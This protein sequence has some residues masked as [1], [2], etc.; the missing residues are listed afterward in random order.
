MAREIAP[1]EHSFYDHM[2]PYAACG[3]QVKVVMG[4]QLVP[5]DEAAAG[6]CPKCAELV[7]AGRPFRTPPHERAPYLCE[8]YL[9]LSVDGRVT[10]EECRLRDFHQGPHRTFDGATWDI[11]LEDYIPAPED[12]TRTEPAPSLA[13]QPAAWPA[14]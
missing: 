11:G 12:D 3:V 13:A 5:A 1:G 8:A 7:A 10:V 6:Q 4:D 14:P 2:G 9:R